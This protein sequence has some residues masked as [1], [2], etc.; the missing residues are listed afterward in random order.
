MAE[1]PDTWQNPQPFGQPSRGRWQYPNSTQSTRPL[2]IAPLGGLPAAGTAHG[3]PQPIATEPPP[4]QHQPRPQPPLRSRRRIGTTLLAITTVLSFTA[5]A[6]FGTLYATDRMAHQ[7]TRNTLT[8]QQSRLD[9]MQQELDSTKSELTAAVQAKRD[10]DSRNAELASRNAQ[11][12]KCVDATGEFFAALQ[13]N[14][15]ARGDRA[16]T[17]MLEG[18]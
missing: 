1:R 4:S 12:Q 11:L 16:I 7:H 17:A 10:Q 2:P 5:A 14:D 18:C 15:Q 3:W 9:S 8:T 6:T 13:A